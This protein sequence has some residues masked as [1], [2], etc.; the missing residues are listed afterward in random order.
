MAK[1]LRETL[2]DTRV[3][4]GILISPLLVTPLLFVV[5]GYFG[6]QKAAQE[7]EEKL[8]VAIVGEGNASGFLEALKA[9]ATLDVTVLPDVA[10]AEAAVKARRCRAALSVPADA[11]AK[12]DA[13][14]SLSIEILYDQGNEKSNT[15]KERLEK[16]LKSFNDQI[17]TARLRTRGLS[18]A[19]LK[20]TEAKPRNIASDSSV[21]S[22]IIATIL[23]Y[24]VVLGGAMGGTT[25]AFDICAGEKERGTME[26][27]LVSP[28]SRTEIILGKV[29]TI[30]VVSF[31]ATTA[32][33]TGLLLTFKF[34]GQ[35]VSKLNLSI[36]YPSLGVVVLVMLPMLG[37]VSSILLVISSFARN[38]KE[39]QAYFIPFLFLMIVPAMLSFVFGA[40]SAVGLSLV[41]ILNTTLAI[42]QILT[43]AVSTPFL[44]LT[45]G[46]TVLYASAALALVVALF[47]REEIL[48]RS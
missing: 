43:N 47:N 32:S 36:S 20:P 1:E 37:L 18:E 22:L 30:W 48:F 38:Q 25:S 2:R 29:L 23:P 34:S 9:D 42:K 31:I 7:R 41:P 35:L 14:E 19:V 39:A 27:L 45:F 17:V 44:A 26:T 6:S 3:L 8:T 10:Q 16:R 12:L 4:F 33:I 15:A 28:A 40:E 46:S 5:M 21:A 24:M 13:N 11:Q